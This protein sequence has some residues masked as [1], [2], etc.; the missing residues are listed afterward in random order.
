MTKLKALLEEKPREFWIDWVN[1]SYN[2]VYKD[3]E[4]NCIHVVDAAYAARLRDELE[5]CVKAIELAKEDLEFIVSLDRQKIIEMRPAVINSKVPASKLI[6]L[7]V[8][9]T[10]L[11]INKLLG[12]D[13]NE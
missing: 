11:K 9:Y 2:G 12:G 10:L 4:P 13:E 5:R 7:R 1:E 6:Q 8:E 3:F